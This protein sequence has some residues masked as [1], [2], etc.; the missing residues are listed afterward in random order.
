[1]VEWGAKPID[2]IRTSTTEAA[3]L[4]NLQGRAGTV[5]A[6]S[7]ADL[8]AVRSDPRLKIDE[9][10]HVRFVMKDGK[11]FKNDADASKL[12]FR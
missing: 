4:L 11:V 2:A 7:F 3:R 9:L 8:I 6:G 5:Q 1:M 12:A 10:E